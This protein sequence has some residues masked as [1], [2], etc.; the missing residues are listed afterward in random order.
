LWIIFL[1]AIPPTCQNWKKRNPW[2]PWLPSHFKQRPT[3]SDQSVGGTHEQVYGWWMVCGQETLFHHAPVRLK[4]TVTKHGGLASYSSK[5]IYLPTYCSHW[6]P[7]PYLHS[8]HLYTS[9]CVF[10]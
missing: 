8:N 3:S 4:L 6:V 7:R 9:S 5:C 1:F 10:L 2:N